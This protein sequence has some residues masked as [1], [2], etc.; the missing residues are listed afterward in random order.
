[1]DAVFEDGPSPIVDGG[2]NSGLV[3][4]DSMDGS[5]ADTQD[6][7]EVVPP[8]ADTSEVA[9]LPAEDGVGKKDS[10]AV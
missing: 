7:S 6:T 1:M 2:W 3:G 10:E 4:T 8:D 9:A 5:D